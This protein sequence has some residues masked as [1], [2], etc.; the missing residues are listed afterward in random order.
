M[1]P[2]VLIIDDAEDF[3]LLIRQYIA[4]EWSDAEIVEWDS[5]AAGSSID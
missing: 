1:T 5:C 4:L 3:R 2:K